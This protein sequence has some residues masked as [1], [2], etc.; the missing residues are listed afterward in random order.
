[1]EGD[2][3]W[4][5]REEK[6]DFTDPSKYEKEVVSHLPMIVGDLAR[7]VEHRDALAAAQKLEMLMEIG[8]L[9]AKVQ[10]MK[11]VLHDVCPLACAEKFEAWMD[12]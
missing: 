1:M 6:R 11:E 8:R 9:E 12:K 2:T 4:Y 3:P 5:E 10:V 7:E